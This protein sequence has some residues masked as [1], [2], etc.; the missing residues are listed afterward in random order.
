M[1]GWMGRWMWRGVCVCVCVWVG[2]WVGVGMCVP[3]RIHSQ[4]QEANAQP[5]KHK[6]ICTYCAWCIVMQQG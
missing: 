3:A 5:T 6:N 4:A 2:G 1:C